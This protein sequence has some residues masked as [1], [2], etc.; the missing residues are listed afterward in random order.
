MLPY[1][2]FKTMSQLTNQLTWFKE[3]VLKQNEVS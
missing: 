3:N 2:T 1:S